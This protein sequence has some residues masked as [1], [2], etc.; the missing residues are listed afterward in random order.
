VLDT[1]AASYAEAGRFDQAGRT[2]SLAIR[3]ATGSKETQLVRKLQERASLYA[4]GQPYRQINNGPAVG[5]D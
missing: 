5:T 1:L 3:L 4:A 2:V